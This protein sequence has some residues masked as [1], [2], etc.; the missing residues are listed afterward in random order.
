[1]TGFLGT[2]GIG[3]LTVSFNRGSLIKG[4]SIGI[5]NERLNF[6]QDITI[7]VNVGSSYNNQVLPI[8][9]RN[10]GETEWSPHSPA[11]CLVQSGICTFTTNHATDYILGIN[12][13]YDNVT[14]VN[15][16]INATISLDC[17]PNITMGVI[18]GDGYSNLAG[19]N[20]LCTIITNNSLGYKLSIKANGG[21]ESLTNQYGNTIDP[22]DLTGIDQWSIS[23]TDSGW[24]YRLST[25][26]TDDDPK[27]GANPDNDNYTTNGSKWN[28]ITTFDFDL[29]SLGNETAQDGSDQYLTFGAQ[30]GV[31]K[32]QPTGTYQTQVIVTGVTN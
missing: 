18:T 8:Y 2:L 5:P 6:S 26:S 7:S 25:T 16:D 9:F 12:I 14:P 30:V 17:D 24:G 15:L 3:L 31:N 10:S 19:N 13:D 11:T 28:K 4:I 32:F 22:I 1:M 20:A 29:N 23:G 27:W 21:S